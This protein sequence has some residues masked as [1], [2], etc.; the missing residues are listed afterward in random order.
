MQ[1]AEP[2][3]FS[4]R[5]IDY[6]CRTWGEKGDPLLILLHGW[7]DNSASWQFTVAAMQ[8]RWRI[9][10][11]DWRGCGRSSWSGA[12]TYWIPDLIADLDVLLDEIEPGEPV[13][14]VGH[15]MGGSIAAMHA[16]AIPGRIRRLVS[17]E[18]MG[19]PSDVAE[20]AP[21]RLA[22]WLQQIRRGSE[23]RPYADYD[24]FAERLMSENPRLTPERAQFLAREW[25][26]DAPDGQGVIRRGDPAHAVLRPN[27]N[28]GDEVV[29][30]WRRIRSEVLWIEGDESEHVE[31][32]RNVEDGYRERLAALPSLVGVERVSGA[33]HN[34]HHD[35]P[36]TL[37]ALIED[38]LRPR[39]YS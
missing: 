25:G 35:Q 26:M 30:L 27:I 19:G 20:E 34:I 3:R 4:I 10:A 16:G 28:R 2:L 18:G 11:P 29:A 9:I 5:G 12:D 21:R 7:Q 8:R 14:V 1:P 37:A 38:F 6:H 33:G 13:D 36:E 32:F 22:R 31:R 24:E 15:S 23:Q 39:G 17:V